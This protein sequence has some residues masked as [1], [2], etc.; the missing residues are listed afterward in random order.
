MASENTLDWIETNLKFIGGSILEVGSKKYND[1][2]HLGL[3]LFLEKYN[4]VDHF[5]GCDLVCGDNV[6]VQVDL[7]GD[8]ETVCHAFKNKKFDTIFCVSVLE[9]IP[10]VFQAANNLQ[11]LLNPGGCI[12]ISVPF[13][14]RNHGYPSDF[15][16]FTPDAISYLFP[17]V[18]FMNFKRSTISTLEKGDVMSLSKGRLEKLNRFIFRPNEPEIIAERKRR[19]ASGENAGPYSLAPCMINMLGVKNG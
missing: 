13:V 18:D 17:E 4:K 16:R 11:S 5:I 9:H 6:D 3:R 1:I 10:N 12:F 2:E 19:K 15:W 8:I 7:S 14:F